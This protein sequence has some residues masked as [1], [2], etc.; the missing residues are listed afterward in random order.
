ML[1]RFR[2]MKWG[3]GARM[4]LPIYGYMM[5]R[6]Y[7]DPNVHISTDEFEAPFEWENSIYNSK[8]KQ[9]QSGSDIEL[10]DIF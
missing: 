10:P 2:S 3:Q 8:N 1:V 7:K 9:H 6:V 4:A 5:Q